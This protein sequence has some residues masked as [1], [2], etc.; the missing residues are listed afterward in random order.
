M[1]LLNVLGRNTIKYIFPDFLMFL[2]KTCHKAVYLSFQCFYPCSDQKHQPLLAVSPG[3]VTYHL[4]PILSGAIA[5]FMVIVVVMVGIWTHHINKAWITQEDLSPAVSIALQMPPL[6]IPLH[7]D[8][9]ELHLKITA[10]QLF[11]PAIILK[12]CIWKI[13][14]IY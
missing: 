3:Q 13:Q 8:R 9:K 7:D 12:C 10:P 4:T 11:P 2:A 14:I 6:T 5:G 1:V